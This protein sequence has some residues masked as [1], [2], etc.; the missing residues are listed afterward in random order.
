M[1]EQRQPKIAP[2]LEI[3]NGYI[4]HLEKHM[5][6]KNDLI[7]EEIYCSK[8]LAECATRERSRRIAQEKNSDISLMLM[9]CTVILC[10][11]ISIINYLF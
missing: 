3:V 1:T 9:I 5:Q 11:V 10:S 7:Q 6:I 4:L 2:S 8:E